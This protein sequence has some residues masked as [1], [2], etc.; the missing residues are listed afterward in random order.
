MS[1][2]KILYTEDDEEIKWF[3]RTLD[4]FLDKTTLIF[5]GSGSGKTTIIEEILY[6]CKDHIPNYI[7][8]VPQTSNGAYIGKLPPACLLEDLT[9]LKIEMIWNRQKHITQLYNTANDINILA[10][11]F[12]K[13]RDPGSITLVQAIQASANNN[14][15]IVKS[16]D[17]LN[18]PK[19]KSLVTEINNLC[20]QKIKNIYKATIRKYRD[21]LTA[22]GKN[23]DLNDK[24]R[25]AL[26]YLDINP[27]LMIIIDDS[28]EKFKMWMSYFKRGQVNVFESIFYKGRHNYISLLFAAHDDTIVDPKLRKNARVVIYT[29]SQALMTSIN[30]PSS[31]FSSQQKKYAQKVAAVLFQDED[32]KIKKHQ[33]LCYIREDNCP[34]RYTIADVY[35][36]FKLGSP[37]LYELAGKLPVKD[38]G[39]TSNPFL[40]NIIKTKTSSRYTKQPYKK[41]NKY[42]P[43]NRKKKYR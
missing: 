12:K 24:E 8:I 40:K 1:D 26:K 6:I 11:L 23:N 4:S 27:R 25:V 30:R 7:V 43:N 33:K 39:L 22:M 2:S 20:T 18:Y 19:K 29:S 10:S 28:S 36:D 31:G 9:K 13:T 21:R 5:G 34:F 42:R 16:N 14:I 35:P 41:Q 38:D 32:A 17:T 3:D 37:S 15:N